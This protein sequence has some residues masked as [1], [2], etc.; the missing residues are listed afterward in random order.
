MAEQ[1]LRRRLDWLDGLRAVA[2]IMVVVSHSIPHWFP[3]HKV[4][5]AFFGPIMIPVFFAISGYLFNLRDGKLGNFLYGLFRKLI[6]PSVFYVL[7]F[8]LPMAP[9]R[10]PDYLPTAFFDLILGRSYWYIP[11]CFLAEILFFLNLKYCKRDSSTYILAGLCCVAG[12]VMDYFGVGD[13]AM[14]SRA[15]IGQYFLAIGYLFRKNESFFRSLSWPVI[16]AGGLVY[17]ILVGVAWMI[18]PRQVIDV[19]MNQYYNVVYCLA[20]ILIVTL[21]LMTSASKIGTAPKLMLELGRNTLAIY[22][23]HS[24]FLYRIFLLLKMADDTSLLMIPKVFTLVVS[25]T[26]LCLCIGMVVNRFFPEI[27]G[28]P[29]V[30]N[31]RQ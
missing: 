16:F 28:R 15:F 31:I 20:L 23:L 6:V 5:S 25:N 29:R 8:R 26:A 1:K 7:F 19:H 2:I 22:L 13:F 21:L 18:W 12:F 10:Q 24:F 30:K 9:F 3:V 27:M 11:A 14:L 4:Y 17:L